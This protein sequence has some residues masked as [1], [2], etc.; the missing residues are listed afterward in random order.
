MRKLYTLAIAAF[1]LTATAAS[2]TGFRTFRNAIPTVSKEMGKQLAGRSFHATPAKAEPQH[3]WV[4]MGEGTM[5]DDITTSHFSVEP[6]A[7]TVDVEKDAANE[8]WYRIVNP[9]KNYTQMD[10]I[11]EAGGTLEQS[12]DITIVID[13][14][15]PDYVRV[16]ETNIGMDDGYGASTVV[17]YTELVGVNLGAFTVTQSDA[18]TKAGK[19]ADGAISFDQRYALMLHQGGDYY[20]GNGNSKFSIA[21]PGT[22]TPIDY[23]LKAAPTTKFCPEADGKYYVT[24]KGD[25]RIP[26]VKYICSTEYPE[27]QQAI[28]ATIA[29]LNA[30]GLTASVNTKVAIDI[31]DATGAEYFMFFCAVDA[32][33]NLADEMPYYL[34]FPVPDTDTAGWHT[35]GNATLT[36]GFLSCSLPTMF[37]VESYQV[38]VQ[39]NIAQPGLYRIVNPY[40][41]WSHSSDYLLAHDHNHYIYFNAENH[42]NVYIL[43]SGLGI[44]VEN[45][46]EAGIGSLYYDMVREYGI[47][48]LNMFGIY[49]G[50]TIKDNVLT[51]DGT[52]EIKIF[53]A[54]TGQWHYTNLKPNPDYEAGV[55]PDE[56]MY[57]GGDFKLD[58]TGLDLSGISDIAADTATATAEYYNLQ[59]IRVEHPSA[60]NVYI[61]R[62]GSKVD[63]VMVR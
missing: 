36:E 23:S 25:E 60:G 31:S 63:K 9:W 44:S 1:A 55:S 24:F 48:L 6:Q 34:A 57:L 51:F 41:P 20:N 43:E 39:R 19:M 28:A 59:G 38:E 26:G 33:G 27:T 10:K 4:A 32:D 16:L 13:A 47:D 2:P 46:G 21:L 12:D 61:R 3:T 29:K 18:D 40:S 14:T 7:I 17:G 49:S 15:D 52:G 37:D 54:G 5:V 50:G 53:F 35:L 45:L 22:E 58:M 8:G 42:E 62:C 30:E 56:D 11:T